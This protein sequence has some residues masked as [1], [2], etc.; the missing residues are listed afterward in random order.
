[1]TLAFSTKSLDWKT[2]YSFDPVGY[3][4]TKTEMISFKR[5]GPDPSPGVWI[6][7]KTSQYNHFHG[8]SYPSKISV[9]SNNDPSATKIF[10]AFS[11]EGNKGDWSAT[12]TTETGET[13]R[14]SFSAGSLVEKEGK[15]YSDIPKN[16]LN[17]AMRLAYVGETTWGNLRAMTDAP[18]ATTRLGRIKLTSKIHAIPTDLLA[19]Q[20]PELTNEQALELFGDDDGY[21]NSTYLQIINYS[22]IP[23]RLS[24]YGPV[25]NFETNLNPLEADVYPTYYRFNSFTGEIEQFVSGALASDPPVPNNYVGI[26]DLTQTLFSTNVWL[27]LGNSNTYDALPISL[28]SISPVEVNGE[29]MRGEYMRVDIERS[30]NDYYELYAVNVDQHK[31]KLDHSLGQNN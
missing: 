27:S 17:A 12:F 4:T 7:D 14:S 24:G 26:S 22:P 25:F 1:M 8:S 15:H 2:Q 21:G 18:Y 23:K 28:Y 19:A 30:G 11:V 5:T 16:T 10:E 3:A 29:D 13:Q 31:T 20:I 9:V 6:H